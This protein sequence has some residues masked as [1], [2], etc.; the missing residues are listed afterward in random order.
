[1]N[2]PA[3]A[4]PECQPH[5]ETERE[6]R[7][8]NAD[9]TM[10]ADC[11]SASEQIRLAT[12]RARGALKTLHPEHVLMWERFAEKILDWADEI[13]NFPMTLVEMPALER[14]GKE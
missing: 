1:M 7:A 9:P 11:W 10:A 5:R 4:P 8:R 12:V 13:E 2:E 6:Y 14:E 3:D